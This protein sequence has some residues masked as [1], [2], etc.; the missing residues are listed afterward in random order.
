MFVIGLKTTHPIL[1]GQIPYERALAILFEESYNFL[2]AG[3]ATL[4]QL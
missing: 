3:R 4:F 1:L 2:S